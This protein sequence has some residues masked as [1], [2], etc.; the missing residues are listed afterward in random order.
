MRTLT[1]WIN[2]IHGR[3]RDIVPGHRHADS[4]I[5]HHNTWERVPTHPTYDTSSGGH[6]GGGAGVPATPIERSEG[7]HDMAR[8]TGD[9][10][11]GVFDS[12]GDHMLVTSPAGSENRPTPK[13]YRAYIMRVDKMKQVNDGLRDIRD[14]LKR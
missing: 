8:P 9:P 14:N 1:H 11:S 3:G 13:L 10:Q 4:P 5:S 2:D 7:K 6:D 12:G